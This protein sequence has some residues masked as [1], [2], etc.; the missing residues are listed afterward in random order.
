MQ[1]IEER[2]GCKEFFVMDENF[3]K[4]RVRAEELLEIMERTGTF[5]YMGVFSSA[6]TIN[7]VGVEFMAKLG[8]DFVWVGVE[9][10]QSMFQKTKGV[11]VKKTI[12]E[13]WARRSYS[14]I[15]TPKRTCR[16][17]SITFSI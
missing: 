5:Y 17:T 1:E 11:D 10:K 7:A 13:F 6:E 15:T 14:W 16:R 4:N 8:I 9:S 3:L 2:L 12:D